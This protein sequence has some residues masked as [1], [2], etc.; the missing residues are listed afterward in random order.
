MTTQETV[1]PALDAFNRGVSRA[2]MAYAADQALREG[3]C[4]RCGREKIKE[5]HA[6]CRC[7][8]AVGT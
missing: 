3:Y 7:R 5:A 6:A 1:S 4:Q 2:R 8:K